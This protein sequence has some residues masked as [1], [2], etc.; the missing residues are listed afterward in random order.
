MAA[1]DDF[2]LHIKLLMLGDTGVGK[3]CAR[4]APSHA[5]LRARARRDVSPT[6]SSSALRARSPQNARSCL[7][8]RYAYDSFSPTFIT[9]IGIDFKIKTVHLGGKKVKLQIWDTAGQ[10][11]FRTI[12]RSY[13]RGAQGIVLVYDITDRR[14]FNSVRSWMAQITDHADQQVNKVLVGN[15]SDNQ[16]ARQVSTQEGQALA[17]EYDVRFIEASAKADVNVTEAFQAIAQQ[18]I[19]RIP[20]GASRPASR[21]LSSKKSSKKSCSC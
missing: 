12:T 10:E 17:A 3:T 14:T 20:R 19:D 8:L 21:Q 15:K 5:R 16:S 11:Q 18:V 7:L 9:T 4:R 2:D 1:D 6:L 13:F